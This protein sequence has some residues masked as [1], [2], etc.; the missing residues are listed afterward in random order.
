M[1]SRRLIVN[2][3]AAVRR[4]GPRGAA[5]PQPDPEIPMHRFPLFAMIAIQLCGC[6]RG[7]PA[8]A[9]ATE[10]AAR[11]ECDR[12][13]ARAIQTGD[14]AEAATLSARAA[15]CYTALQPSTP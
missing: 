1:T 15:E 5:A 8:A 9:P 4:G 10:D 6:G 13:A 3:A 7:A 12:F 2:G 14:P 11:I